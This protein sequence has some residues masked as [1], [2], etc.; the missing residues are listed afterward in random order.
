MAYILNRKLSSDN[1][2]LENV[3][4]AFRD[5]SHVFIKTQI[6]YNDIIVYKIPD[7]LLKL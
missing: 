7:F 1:D 6:L 3:S 2:Y 5:L 4:N